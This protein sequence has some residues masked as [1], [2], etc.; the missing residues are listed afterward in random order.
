MTNTNDHTPKLF[1]RKTWLMIIP[2]MLGGMAFFLYHQY[3]VEG[4]ISAI[5]I[6]IT[7]GT[8]CFLLAIAGVIAWWGNR[9][10]KGETHE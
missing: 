1:T 10:E 3:R 7:I 6:A 9:P 5:T 8:L 2:P 4:E